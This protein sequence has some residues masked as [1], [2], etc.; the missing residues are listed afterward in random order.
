MFVFVLVV[1]LLGFRLDTSS[2]FFSSAGRHPV[3]ENREIVSYC[4][5]A[6]GYESWKETCLL[7]R[8]GVGVGV[9]VGFGVG[10][11]ELEQLTAALRRIV[12]IVTSSTI[13]S[14]VSV[15][16]TFLHE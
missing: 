9:R 12:W 15:G 10:G 3:F 11:V 16:Y 7:V 4:T 8:A 14:C 13:A 5:F 2:S 6:L 1:V